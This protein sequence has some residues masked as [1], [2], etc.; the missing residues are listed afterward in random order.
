MVFQ[1]LRT[2]S[3]DSVWWD[4]HIA[5][6]SSW[7]YIVCALHNTNMDPKTL[8]MFSLLMN[9]YRIYDKNTV[10]YSPGITSIAHVDSQSTY[11]I[12]IFTRLVCLLTEE[13]TKNLD[14]QTF[15]LPLNE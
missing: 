14:R 3:A 8:L 12:Y 13:V 5:T 10:H 6:L 2:S 7:Y 11:F 9:L 4:R 15:L 1:Q